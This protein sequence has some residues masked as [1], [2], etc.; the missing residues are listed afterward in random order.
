[1]KF[2]KSN[3]DIVMKRPGNVAGVS[4]MLTSDYN[5]KLYELI[6]DGSKFTTCDDKQINIIRQKVDTMANWYKL[7]S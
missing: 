7:K 6:R 5:H 4:V 3:K 1:M 2:L